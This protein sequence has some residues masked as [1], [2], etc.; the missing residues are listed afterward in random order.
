MAD[1]KFTGL[2]AASGIPDNGSVLAISTYDGVSTYTSEKYT[3]TQVKDI[4]YVMEAEDKIS[5][6]GGTN[7][8]F[9][10]DTTSNA[11][12][13]FEDGGNTERILLSADGSDGNTLTST[14]LGLLD[15]EF[16]LGNQGIEFGS[17]AS[18]STYV[19]QLIGSAGGQALATSNL[20][21]TTANIDS[22]TVSI[23]GRATVLHSGGTKTNSV[24]LGG[25]GLAINKD[26]YAFAQNLEVQ[27][28]DFAHTSASGKFGVFGAT[29]IVQPTTGVAAATFTANTSGIADDTATFDGYTIGQVVKALR[30]EGLLA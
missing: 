13:Y 18:G 8:I 27:G 7:K 22:Q 2:S 29:P 15:D 5:F 21:Y 12:I 30:N 23:A 9:A 28:G 4:V 6:T 1:I 26:D 3:M 20:S 16:Y 11:A 19:T 25:V 14:Y 10:Q 24:G 17:F